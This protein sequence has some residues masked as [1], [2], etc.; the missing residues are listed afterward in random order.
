MTHHGLLHWVRLLV[1]LLSIPWA[2]PSQDVKLGSVAGTVVEAVTRTPLED[3]T[4]RATV[5]ATASEATTDSAGRYTLGDLPPGT[6]TLTATHGRVVKTRSLQLS[7]GRRLEGVDFSL[8]QTGSISGRVLDE[9]G[10][11][12]EEMVV[13]LLGR[14][15]R[16]GNIRY[17]P[18]GAS[19]TDDRGVYR[20]DDMAPGHV[21]LLYVRPYDRKAPA[22]AEAPLDPGFRQPVDAE[23]FYPQA[24][25]V[26][27]AATVE[28]GPGE[29]RQGVDI[30]LVRTP[31]YCVE[32]RLSA[33]GVPF[34]G[35][36]R[37]IDTQLLH[38]PIGFASA[39]NG[40]SDVEGKLRVCDVAPG[41][42]ELFGY[43]MPNERGDGGVSGRVRFTVVDAD[44]TGLE[45]PAASGSPMPVNIEWEGPA[46]AA[47]LDSEI[48][49][50]VTPVNQ[51]YIQGID[52]DLKV[53]SPVPGGGLF[54]YL[55]IAEYEVRLGG[56]GGDMHVASAKYGNQD[57]LREPLRFGDAIG[58]GELTIVL[59]DGAGSL[60]ALVEDRK[61]N[62]VSDVAV[63]V[64]PK[65]VRSEADLADAF[66]VATTDESGRCVVKDLAPGP[67]LVMATD[68]PV[69]RAVESMERIWASRR[70][71]TAVLV[72]PAGAPAQVTLQAVA[73][74]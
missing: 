13:F 65:D 2:A 59:K 31:S 23:T 36:F 71:A 16:L 42:Y 5:G 18:R 17:T 8:A 74:Q 15:Y 64:F 26:R 53:T 62:P 20:I 55:K 44:V 27:D 9:D 24:R 12:K 54:P 28:I 63:V 70:R 51:A 57:V 48:S 37:V 1:C 19:K 41:D 43:R 67:Y 30:R 61:G 52:R 6:H 7:P 72:E 68:Q 34:T 21:N 38:G 73:G 49:I 58:G 4:V 22:M 14:E 40:D 3:V 10:E 35:K 56:L 66:A 39:V 46:D 60:T 29:H 69:S 32:S 33:A 47:L 45:M 50:R 25:S 11:P